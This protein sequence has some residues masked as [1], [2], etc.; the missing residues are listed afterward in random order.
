MLAGPD[1]R[2]PTLTPDDITTDEFLGHMKRF[3]GL[4]LEAYPDPGSKDGRPWTIGYGHTGGV[5]PGM[6]IAEEQA[7]ELLRHDLALP[8]REAFDALRRLDAPFSFGSVQALASLIFNIGIGAW[9]SSTLKA[10]VAS[11]APCE[12]IAEA[13][14]MWRYNDGE[15]MPG[16]VNRRVA[17][18][19]MWYGRPLTADERDRLGVTE[20]LGGAPAEGPVAALQDAL[21]RAG[22]DPGPLDGLWGPNTR[23]AL[24]AWFGDETEAEPAPGLLKACIPLIKET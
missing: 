15:M 10:R 22:Y 23:A 20:W 21:G 4:R 11:G 1:H 3:E 19:E 5:E 13:F 6:R 2:R 24:R 18:V 12:A 8:V 17:E 7:D 16:L 14:L 9:R